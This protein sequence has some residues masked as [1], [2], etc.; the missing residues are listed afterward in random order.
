M[1]ISYTFIDLTEAQERSRLIIKQLKP[2]IIFTFLV[3][4]NSKTIYCSV[5]KLLKKLRIKN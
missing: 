3:K 2:K 4:L 1:G 5:E